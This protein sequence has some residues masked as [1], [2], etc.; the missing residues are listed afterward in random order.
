MHAWKEREDNY[1]KQSVVHNAVDVAQRVFT[2]TTPHGAKTIAM[3]WTE[4]LKHIP[5]HKDEEDDDDE[6]EENKS[7]M[8]KIAVKIVWANLLLWLQLL[9]YYIVIR[10]YVLGSACVIHI[11][12]QI[13]LFCQQTQVC[14][15]KSIFLFWFIKF[16][17]GKRWWWYSDSLQTER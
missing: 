16:F 3:E 2:S 5:R 14:Q 11:S 6:K 17:H 9:L 15:H 1:V 7:L 10:Y 4:L 8:V 12:L 13:F